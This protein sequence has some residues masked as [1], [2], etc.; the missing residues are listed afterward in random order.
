ML[1]L[2]C[3][4]KIEKG[5]ITKIDLHYGGSIGIDKNILDACDLYGNEV[6]QVLNQNNGERFETYI[7]EEPAGSGL[8][9][10]YGPAARLGEVGDTLYILS[11]AIIED[12]E[13]HEHKIKV[14]SLDSDN[15]VRNK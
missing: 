2:V 9:A 8:I 6:V 15:K 11:Q 10:L 13:I 4:S 5:T 3:K 7:I 14:V 1:R 12:K